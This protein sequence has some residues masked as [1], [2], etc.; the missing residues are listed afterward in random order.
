MSKLKT[1]R[2]EAGISQREL[3]EKAGVHITAIGK[4]ESGERSFGKLRLETALKIA[5]ALSADVRSLIDEE[6]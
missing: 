3:A 5:D 2:S 6:D 4:L 1:A